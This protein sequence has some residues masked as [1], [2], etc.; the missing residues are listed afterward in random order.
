[1][2][3]PKGSRNRTSISLKIEALAKKLYRSP[4]TIRAIRQ[5]RIQGVPEVHEAMRAAGLL[6]N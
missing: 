1:M 4:S 2:P 6:R 5:G 3:R